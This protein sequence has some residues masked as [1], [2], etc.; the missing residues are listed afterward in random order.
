MP[1]V[2]LAELETSL[3]SLESAPA[4]PLRTG[5]P[6]LDTLLGGGFPAGR[7]IEISGPRSSGKAT[8]ALTALAQSHATTAC[9]DPHRELYPP[10]VASL[11]VDL[12]R[13]LWIAPPPTVVGVLRAGEILTR[14]RAFA[15]VLLDFPDG[16]RVPHA[17]ASRLRL[18]AH[19][20]GTTLLLLSTTAEALPHAAVRL[21]V[22]R[23]LPRGLRVTLY[24]GGAAPPGTTTR[25]GLALAS[26][27]RPPEH[28]ARLQGALERLP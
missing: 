20:A 16:Q 11:G 26:D 28:S 25:L 10:S 1:S 27:F 7:L 9:V 17:I 24:K 18:W 12:A 21:G 14:S 2:R 4:S 8:L 13:L 5:F 19:Q 15:L 22:A 6:T 3:R 23:Q